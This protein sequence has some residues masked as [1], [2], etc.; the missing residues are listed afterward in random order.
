LLNICVKYCSGLLDI[1]AAAVGAAKATR[2]DAPRSMAVK[3][4][5]VHVVILLQTFGSALRAYAALVKPVTVGV[6]AVLYVVFVYGNL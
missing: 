3:T 4:A 5:I 6:Q 2:G 1:F